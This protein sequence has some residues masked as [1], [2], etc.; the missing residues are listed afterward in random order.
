MISPAAIRL[1][2][3][4]EASIPELASPTR[5]GPNPLAQPDLTEI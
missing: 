3:M 1:T 2:R 5:D 4:S